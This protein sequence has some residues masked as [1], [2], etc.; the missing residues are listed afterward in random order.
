MSPIYRVC[1]KWKEEFNGDNLE[2]YNGIKIYHVLEKGNLLRLTSIHN[3]TL[4]IN[5]DC[6]I[7]FTAKQM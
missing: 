6:V 1:V 4:I 2:V 5:L 7:S 3:E